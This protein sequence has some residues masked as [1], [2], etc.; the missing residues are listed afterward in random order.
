MHQRLTFPQPPLLTIFGLFLQS[1]SVD[2][3][4]QGSKYLYIIIF[5]FDTAVCLP[6]LSALF[7]Y[8]RVFQGNNR[9][10][11]L[12]IWIAMS[13]V[14]GWLF[15][16]YIST[17]FQCT[18]IAKAWD[19]RIT[20]GSCINQYQ[21]Y[22]A[23]AALSFLIDIYILIL[24][25]PVIWR[26][27]M[28]LK[29]RISLLAAFFLA[30]SVIVLSIGRLVST[31][32]IVPQLYSDLDWYFPSYAYWACLEPAISLICIS[33]PNIAN[34]VRALVP[35]WGASTSEPTNGRRAAVT[36]SFGNG[37]T[38]YRS[39]GEREGFERLE[40]TK[41]APISDTVSTELAGDSNDVALG[42]IHVKT[43][44]NVENETRGSSIADDQV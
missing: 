14:V 40:S 28:S 30:Y 22:L 35:G 36:Q 5:F 6:K 10:L 15:S 25:V 7:F 3:V 9:I 13:L 27:N 42:R 23:T 1:M 39:R 43:D 16:A 41:G 4:L 19:P 32:I 20:D 29:R 38:A 18:P 33:V 8:V 12:N 26:L 21:W 17:I 34:L 11:S 24:P 31:T 44:I 2:Y 37:T